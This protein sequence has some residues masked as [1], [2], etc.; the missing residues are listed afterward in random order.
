[1]SRYTRS[2]MDPDVFRLSSHSF[3]N[4]RRDSLFPRQATTDL[5]RSLYRVHYFR[6]PPDREDGYHFDSCLTEDYGSDRR[7][8]Y[9]FTSSG[10]DIDDLVRRYARLEV[11]HAVSCGADVIRTNCNV[12]LTNNAID[13]LTNTTL[14][15][16]KVR[17]D[18]RYPLN[19]ATP[20]TIAHFMA[21]PEGQIDRL[22]EEYDIPVR[23]SAGYSTWECDCDSTM[24]RESRASK[25][26][27]LLD[28][29]GAL[30]IADVLR[31]GSGV[32]GGMSGKRPLMTS[33]RR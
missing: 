26:S 22:L 27:A 15:Q 33:S 2:F 24:E 1:M 31:S 5:S 16:S 18:G 6:Q 29:L 32:G 10:R 7:R 23:G 12:I 9:Q 30:R 28:F 14:I 8:L 4:T 25:L 3:Y 13:Q 11:Y 17:M 21:L 20:M 19:F